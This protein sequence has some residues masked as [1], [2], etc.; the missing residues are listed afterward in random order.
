[1]G[2]W[3][4]EKGGA[5]VGTTFLASLIKNE[6][7]TQGT[8]SLPLE[9]PASRWS[10]SF[11]LEGVFEFQDSKIQFNRGFGIF[12]LESFVKK[13]RDDFPTALHERFL[14]GILLDY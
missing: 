7:G 8:W 10:L 13:L 5:S 3:K 6:T 9:A 12:G 2:Q 4:G 14:S 1:M 11:S